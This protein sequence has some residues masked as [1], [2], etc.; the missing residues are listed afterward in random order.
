P[1]TA[2]PSDWGVYPNVLNL[3]PATLAFLDD[4][5]TEVMA[6]FPGPYI[7]VGGDE[8]DTSQW[9]ASPRVQER[10]RELGI[11]DVKDIQH[12]ITR[13]IARFIESRGRRLVGW[14]EILEPDLARSAVVMSWRGNR[15]ALA[16]AAQGH[17]SVLAADPTLY[18]DHLQTDSAS[19]PPGR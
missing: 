13:R 2:V 15:G 16:A 11:A 4:V 18:F 5:L 8:V 14:D 1:P 19:E 10:M 17:D 7:H 3:E 6:I 12:W 9:K